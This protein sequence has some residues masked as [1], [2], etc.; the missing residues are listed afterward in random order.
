[1]TTVFVTHDMNEAMKLADRICIMKK[2]K[3]IQI[4]TPEEIKNNPKNEFV[5]EFL[6]MEG[7]K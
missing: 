1:M 2:G 3:I 7:D 6:K 5:K 4:A